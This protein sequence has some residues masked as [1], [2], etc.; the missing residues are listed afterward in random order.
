M[1]SLDNVNHNCKG[2]FWE[3]LLKVGLTECVAKFGYTQRAC[4]SIRAID[5][6]VL[7][8][9]KKEKKEMVILK[10]QVLACIK[11]ETIKYGI[12]TLFCVGIQEKFLE[13]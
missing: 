4:T 12:K 10:A 1:A 9:K 11:D 13:S 3:Q 8:F 2:F 7:S 6:S 5:F